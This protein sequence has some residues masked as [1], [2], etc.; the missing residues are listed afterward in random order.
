MTKL[1]DKY[2][3]K[4]ILIVDDDEM[5]I[6]G[7]KMVLEEEGYSVFAAQNVMEAMGMIGETLP[8]MVVID[9]M[10]PDGTGDQL[11]RH[12]R[13]SIELRQVPILMIS[14]SREVEE[15]ALAAGAD[16]FVSKPFD[17]E[18]LLGVVRGYLG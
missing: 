4:K 10:L 9:M 8:H 3:K 15:K 5:L 7:M 2:M 16:W 14:A 1:F 6:E 17:M 11:T 13:D 18:V 12:L